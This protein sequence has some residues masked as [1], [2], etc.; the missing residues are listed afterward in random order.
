MK[1][2]L[3]ADI[4][5][6]IPGFFTFLPLMKPQWLSGT[7]ALSTFNTDGDHVNGYTLKTAYLC[8]RFAPAFTHPCFAVI[9]D[10]SA[11]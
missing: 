2:F 6:A 1:Q 5:A 7:G 4:Q 3:L 9:A 10:V 11:E 8:R